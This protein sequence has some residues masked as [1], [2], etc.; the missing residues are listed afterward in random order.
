[1]G[2]LFVLVFFFY[3]N[4]KKSSSVAGITFLQSSN[5][6]RVVQIIVC[7]LDNLA[8]VFLSK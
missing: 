2:I 7:S 4:L 3:L 5:I 6:F 1:M 8:E